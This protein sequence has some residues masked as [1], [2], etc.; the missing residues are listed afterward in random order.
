MST[1]AAAVADDLDTGDGGRGRREATSWKKRQRPCRHLP[2]L[3]L[4]QMTCSGGGGTS[5]FSTTSARDGDTT[6]A[7]AVSFSSTMD[8][9]AAGS[10]KVGRCLMQD[11]AW[12]SSGL[13]CHA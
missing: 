5:A 2:A 7:V 9:W 6:S 11:C 12:P 13:N 10:L 8:V 3:N 1:L 4:R